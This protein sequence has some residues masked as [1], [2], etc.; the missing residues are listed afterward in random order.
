[1]FKNDPLSPGSIEWYIWAYI[2]INDIE[3]LDFIRNMYKDI[4]YKEIFNK[5]LY[6]TTSKPKMMQYLIDNGADYFDQAMNVAAR[7]GDLEA[8][9]LLQENGADLNSKFEW[10][11]DEYITPLEASLHNDNLNV[12]LYLIDQGA[13]SYIASEHIDFFKNYMKTITV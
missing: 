11:E 9:K 6:I 4:P 10:Y 8:V 3:M 5:M 2:T 12:A 1:M 13:T 7:N